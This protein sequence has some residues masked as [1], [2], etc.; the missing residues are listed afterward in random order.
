M[1]MFKFKAMKHLIFIIVLLFPLIGSGQ[2]FDYSASVETGY[3]TG[4]R[5]LL[6]QNIITDDGATKLRYPIGMQIQHP[7]PS[8]YSDIQIGL[9]GFDHRL[10][11]ETNVITTFTD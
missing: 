2:T 10:N 5:Y 7:D 8:F 3:Y 9:H 4:V 11:F 1:Q 6:G